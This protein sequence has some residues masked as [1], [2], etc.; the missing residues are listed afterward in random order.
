MQI[1]ISLLAFRNLRVY[2]KF[3]Q[4]HGWRR[5]PGDETSLEIL[6]DFHCPIIWL[7][8]SSSSSSL[9]DDVDQAPIAVVFS[10]CKWYVTCVYKCICDLYFALVIYS[11]SRG[12]IF[13]RGSLTVSFDDRSE[14]L[15]Y[16][17]SGSIYNHVWVCRGL[18]RL[19][20]TF[21][22]QDLLFRLRCSASFLWEV[23]KETDE[24][25][26]RK[27]YLDN[28][29]VEWHWGTFGLQTGSVWL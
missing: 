18:L 26:S 23:C 25:A 13:P 12:H 14:R 5:P 6:L 15:Y 9:Q 20:F 1:L 24:K 10:V 4:V 11:I 29:S 27:D 19:S 17:S 16:S 21:H 7:L 22:R 8:R 2:S 3:Q 28:R